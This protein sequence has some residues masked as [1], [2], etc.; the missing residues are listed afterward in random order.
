MRY[1]E[2]YAGMFIVRTKGLPWLRVLSGEICYVEST[3]DGEIHLRITQDCVPKGDIYS[4]PSQAD[5]GFWYDVS[6]LVLDANSCIAPSVDTLAFPAAVTA[7]YRNFLG[8]GSVVS[9]L[10]NEDAVGK[11]C[12]L[13]EATPAG[14]VFAKNGFY[15][16]SCDEEGYVIGYQGYCDY[17][18]PDDKRLLS[19]RILN[20]NGTNRRFYPADSIVNACITA[21][22][23]DCELASTYEKQIGEDTIVSS[24]ESS[25]AASHD[26]VSRIQLEAAVC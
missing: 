13:G 2:I 17:C 5:D 9:P 23:E 18:A 12:M 11:I 8:L 19:L 1:T 26:G 14:V 24:A 6:D 10:S 4:V 21:Y 20:L 22:N 7:N 3:G 16:I 15:V 25:L